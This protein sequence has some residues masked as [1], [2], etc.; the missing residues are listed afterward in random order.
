MGG[1]KSIR[2]DNG[3]GYHSPDGKWHCSNCGDNGEGVVTSD[4]MLLNGLDDKSGAHLPMSQYRFNPVHHGMEL[5]AQAQRQEMLQV[6][7]NGYR[8]HGF[9]SRNMTTGVTRV[10]LINKY[11]NTSQQVRLTLSGRVV[12]ANCTVVTLSDDAAVFTPG[13]QRWGTVKPPQKL[14]CPTGVCQFELPPI[15]FSMLTVG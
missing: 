7:S 1:S 11:G 15:S 10:F 2:W 5:M 12:V 4:H 3:A 9:A 13:S 8:L 14:N 6:S